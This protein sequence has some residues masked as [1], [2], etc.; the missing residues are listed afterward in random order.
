MTVSSPIEDVRV[1]H[2]RDGIVVTLGGGLRESEV[3][4]ITVLPIVRDMFSDTLRYPF[5]LILSTGPEFE[6]NVVAGIVEDRVAGHTVAGA[7]VEARFRRRND[8]VTHW[9]LTDAKSIF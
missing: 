2:R 3:H 1:R 8:A 5:D 7:L 9:N 4:R 6:P